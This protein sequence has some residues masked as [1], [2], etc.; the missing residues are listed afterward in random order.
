MFGPFK[1]VSSSKQRMLTNLALELMEEIDKIQFGNKD[2]FL[3]MSPSQRD[4]LHKYYKA[5]QHC[6]TWGKNWDG[7]DNMQQILWNKAF[8]ELSAASMIMKETLKIA[9]DDN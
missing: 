9:E 8:K 2:V 3:S 5:A 6:M 1:K 4:A 7:S